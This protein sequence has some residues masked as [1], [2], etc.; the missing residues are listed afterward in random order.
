MPVSNTFWFNAWSSFSSLCLLAGVFKMNTT[1][2]SP[3]T[4]TPLGFIPD[5]KNA[6]L[7]PFNETACENWKEIH[8]LVFHVANICFAVGLVI[9]TTL[10]FHMIFLR[11][12]LT[13]GRWLL[14]EICSL[15]VAETVNITRR[16][17]S[18]FRLQGNSSTYSWSLCF[19][20][21]TF[22]VIGGPFWPD[23]HFLIRLCIRLL[24]SPRAAT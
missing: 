22:G 12:L 15:P 21:G 1:A 20:E 10:N 9:P 17:L 7:V 24:K 16:S 4:V 6:T 14:W 18:L 23:R 13:I 3:L 5:L 11:G 8:H 19:A 2:I